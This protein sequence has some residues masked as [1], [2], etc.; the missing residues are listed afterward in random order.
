MKGTRHFFILASTVISQLT[1]PIE[2][3][4][5][6]ECAKLKGRPDTCN[7]NDRKIINSTSEDGVQC[8]VFTFGGVVVGQGM[9]SD[10]LCSPESLIR[11]Q[12]A[13]SNA[14]IGS[15]PTLARCCG[16][17]L[18]NGEETDSLAIDPPINN[19]TDPESKREKTNNETTANEDTSTDPNR[20][21]IPTTPI[22]ESPSSM[23][24]T[25][26]KRDNMKINEPVDIAT[27]LSKNEGEAQVASE[28]E[29]G[30]LES[31]ASRRNIS[32]WLIV[33][34]T[35]TEIISVSRLF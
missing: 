25:A 35:G 3:L 2:S 17:S 15:G 24:S 26:S 22:T 27:R 4:Q 14:F 18:C 11:S 31:E 6:Y 10:V 5:C 12:L 23:N 9:V 8:R 29:A 30:G 28:P 20:N 21:S 16:D 34:L 1:V 13:I 7:D 19:S 32:F 33:F